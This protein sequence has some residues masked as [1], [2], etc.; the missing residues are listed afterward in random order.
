MRLSTVDL[1]N[2]LERHGHVLDLGNLGQVE[3]VLC[4]TATTATHNRRRLVG[5]IRVEKVRV[6]DKRGHAC[7][8]GEI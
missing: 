8:K 7:F 3:L 1:L 5:Q 2:E 6:A 4:A